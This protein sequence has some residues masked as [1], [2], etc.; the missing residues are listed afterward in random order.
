MGVWQPFMWKTNILELNPQ[1]SK[2]NLNDLNLTFKGFTFFFQEYP[3]MFIITI[4]SLPSPNEISR[5]K[6]LQH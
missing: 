4:K 2:N 6:L 5:K 3:L 1:V